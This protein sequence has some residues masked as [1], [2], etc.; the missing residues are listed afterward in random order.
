MG[1][2]KLLIKLLLSLITAIVLA[3]GGYRIIQRDSFIVVDKIWQTSPDVGSISANPYVRA[4]VA[5]TG[6]L[7]LNKSE[8]S[9]FSAEKDE[10]GA[11]LSSKCIYS[12]KGGKLNAD[13]WSITAY[14]DDH[15]LIKNDENRFSFNNKTL[16]TGTYTIKLSA[17][18]QAGHWLPIPKTGDFSLL[19]RL[20]K[21]NGALNGL[22]VLTKESC[23]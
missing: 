6:L 2:M 14:A 9:Y 4:H 3:Y 16:G 23:V 8:T 21:P 13:W 19:L 20:Y 15:F 1:N 22:P 11:K 7:A 12:L 17:E 18:K 10:T 5:I